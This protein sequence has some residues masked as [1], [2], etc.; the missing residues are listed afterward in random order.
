VGLYSSDSSSCI[1]SDDTNS[2]SVEELSESELEE[3]V[4]VGPKTRQYALEESIGISTYQ[5]LVHGT[6]YIGALGSGQCLSRT[7]HPNVRNRSVCQGSH[8]LT[9]KMTLVPFPTSQGNDLPIAFSSNVQN[10]IL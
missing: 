6:S 7:L 9:P 1:E 2:E 5:S 8:G 10:R 3:S 4:N